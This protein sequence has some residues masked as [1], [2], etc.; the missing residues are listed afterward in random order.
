M[1]GKCSVYVRPQLV[2]YEIM[3]LVRSARMGGPFLMQKVMWERNTPTKW[4]QGAGRQ[5]VNGGDDLK[6]GKLSQENLSKRIDELEFIRS[7]IEN[8]IYEKGDSLE[9][10]VC[11]K[12]A[13][14]QHGSSVAE[15]INNEG[16]RLNGRKYIGKD[17]SNI[18][19]SSNCGNLS[20]VAKALLEYN[21][22]LQNGTRSI[23]KLIKAFKG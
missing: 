7:T 16:Y 1:F 22:T 21:N 3:G 20:K 10:C 4:L 11:R 5:S 18:I 14:L 17:I 9:E 19:K 23:A 13:E 8:A 6:M 12:Y 15:Y 2:K